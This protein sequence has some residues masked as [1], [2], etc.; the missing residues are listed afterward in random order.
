MSVASNVERMMLELVNDERAKVGAPPLKLELNLNESAETHSDWMLDTDRFSHTGE[1]GSSAGERMSDAGFDFDGSWRWA[2]NIAW[3]SERGERGIRDDVEDLHESLMNSPGHRAN[4]LNPDLDVMGIGVE[5]GNFAGYDAV[6]VSQ[7][8]ASTGGSLD[9]DNGGQGVQSASQTVDIGP[10]I[11]VDDIFVARARGAWREKLAK[12]TETD[13]SDGDTIAF[14]EIRDDEGHHNFRMRG[15]GVIDATD[16]VIIAAD[17]FERLRVR[18]D[19]HVGETTVE[20]RA[21]DGENWGDWADITVV[22]QSPDDYF[23]FA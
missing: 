12:H 6:M 20:M 14:Y 16:G 8:F 15:E 13:E 22:T 11:T 3:Q 18:A 23:G 2:E 7:N 5:R 1:G 19:D 17:D 10:S 4:I 21:S 9:I